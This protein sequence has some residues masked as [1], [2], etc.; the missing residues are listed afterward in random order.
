MLLGLQSDDRHLRNTAVFSKPEMFRGKMLWLLQKGQSSSFS[1]NG[2]SSTQLLHTMFKLSN[3]HK[4]KVEHIKPRP[5]MGDI[6]Y[7]YKE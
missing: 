6:F 3:P 4:K 5:K 1:L 7:S 2:L